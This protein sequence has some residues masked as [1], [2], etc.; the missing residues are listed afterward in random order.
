[1]AVGSST[2]ATMRAVESGQVRTRRRHQRGEFGDE[3]DRLELHVRGAVAPRRLELVAHPALR[4][5]R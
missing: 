2:L 4:R 1:M 5:D 3:L